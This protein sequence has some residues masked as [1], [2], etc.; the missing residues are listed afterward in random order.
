MAVQRRLRPELIFEAEPPPRRL[1]P[2]AYAVGATV[3]AE[4]DGDA[5]IGWGK[6]VLDR[7]SVV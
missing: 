5:E 4:D 2:F 1:A 7:K 3:V 6:F